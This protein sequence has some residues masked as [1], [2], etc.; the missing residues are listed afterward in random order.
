[1]DG[2]CSDDRLAVIGQRH[3][4]QN[5]GMILRASYAAM[6]TDLVFKPGQFL[7]L[8]VIDCVHNQVGAVRVTALTPHVRGG[9]RPEDR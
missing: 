2:D 1:M 5:E 6:M 8:R 7:G 3:R 9:I 4:T